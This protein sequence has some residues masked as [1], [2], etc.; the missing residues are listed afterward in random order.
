M[1][2]IVTS[3]WYT[4]HGLCRFSVKWRAGV[5]RSRVYSHFRRPSLNDDASAHCSG[6][7]WT[8]LLK[9][10]L[11][12]KRKS[13]WLVPRFTPHSRRRGAKRNWLGKGINHGPE[14]CRHAPFTS[15]DT[16][17]GS[18]EAIPEAVVQLPD[19]RR[20]RTEAASQ[21]RPHACMASLA[22]EAS[23]RRAS[24]RGRSGGIERGILLFPISNRCP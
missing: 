7:W 4:R 11:V 9:L 18:S 13:G 14:P 5:P 1:L 20:L 16:L 15:G 10:Q 22:Q 23:F 8:R 2:L 19:G 3:G 6:G 12:S 24:Q 17:R 21:P